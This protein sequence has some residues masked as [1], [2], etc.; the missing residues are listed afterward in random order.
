MN[1]PVMYIRV[2]SV[3]VLYGD[4]YVGVAVSPIAIPS[5]FMR[6]LVMLVMTVLV[7]VFQH[8]MHVFMGMVLGQVQPYTQ[9]H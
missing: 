2:M 8:F 9:A 3:A 6:M 7:A 4:M 1:V 5:K